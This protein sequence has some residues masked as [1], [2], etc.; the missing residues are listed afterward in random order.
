MVR[1]PRII[2]RFAVG[3]LLLSVE[4]GAVPPSIDGSIEK[5][6]IGRHSSSL[7]IRCLGRV[8]RLSVSLYP[9]LR[10]EGGYLQTSA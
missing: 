4:E 1:S 2:C 9:T 5:T 7:L 3:L 8:A 10:D 6:L